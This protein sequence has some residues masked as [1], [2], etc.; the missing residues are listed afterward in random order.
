MVKQGIRILLISGAYLLV[1][2]LGYMGFATYH[3][4]LTGWFLI[5]TVLSYGLGGPF[6]LME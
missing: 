3:R 2:V 4:N 1:C 5:L 6:L